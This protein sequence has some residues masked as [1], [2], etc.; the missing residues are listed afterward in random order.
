[1]WQGNP[2]LDALEVVRFPGIE[3]MRNMESGVRKNSALGRILAPYRLLN[4]T[5]R[6]LAAGKYD[7]GIIL[8]FDHWWGAAMLAA[9]G[10]PRR[11]GYDT[12]GMKAWLTRAVPYEA[13]KHEVEQNLA[14]VEAIIAG[15]G[16]VVGGGAEGEL[17]S[18]VST[19]RTPLQIDRA[20]GLPPLRPPHGEPFRD[21]LLEPWLAA[22][23]RVVIHPGT[24]AANKLWTVSG[25][26]EVARNLLGEGWAVA[27]TG[28]PD[29][30]RLA[31]AV[32][33]ATGAALQEGSM[34][35]NISGR[36]ASLAQLVW[37][38]GQAGMVLGVDSGPLHIADALGKPSLHLYGPSDETIWGPWG[39]PSK[40]RAFRAPGT[41]P[42][43]RLDTG[44]PE[45]E[46]GPE[47]RRITVAMVMREIDLLAGNNS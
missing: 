3:R 11:W 42:T 17:S 8:R 4:A 20:R 6:R 35:V 36:T 2:N 27:I 14:L 19:M 41:N 18:V 24:T 40:H 15:R 34:L 22:A 43:M 45:I 23:R 33:D 1:M 32:M 26:A 44:S 28:S 29:E 30:R 37:L 10:V 47:M 7:L 31:A 12:P 16:P 25:W 13:G 46:G 9:A 21:E 5:A 39:D 38:L